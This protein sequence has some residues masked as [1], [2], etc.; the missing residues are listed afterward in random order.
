MFAMISA[1]SLSTVIRILY[2]Y[3]FRWDSADV[4][5]VFGAVFADR[6]GLICCRI[7]LVVGGLSNGACR[8]H[9]QVVDSSNPIFGQYT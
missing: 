7:F 5:V 1:K 4:D 8:S 9:R 6:I 3:G 2:L